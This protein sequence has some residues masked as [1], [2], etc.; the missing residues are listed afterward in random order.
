MRWRVSYRRR[1]GG[2]GAESTLWGP[3]RLL[4]RGVDT[5]RTLPFGTPSDVR[6]EVLERCKVLG[7]G[8]GFVFNPVHNIQAY[9]PIPNI[10]AMIDA[11]REYNGESA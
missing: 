2:Q 10:I 7:K 9:T 5:Q 11:I 4:G 8:G 3:Y 1:Y 6:K